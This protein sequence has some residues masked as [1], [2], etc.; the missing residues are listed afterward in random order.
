[1]LNE[2]YREVLVA[3]ATCAAGLTGLLFVAISVAPRESGR[4]TQ[5]TVIQQVRA[6]SALLAF[7]NA[8]AV[9][10]FSLVPGDTGGQAALAL[11]SIGIL[12]TAASVRS[13]VTSPH[14]SS[15]QAWGQAGLITIL[16]AAFGGEFGCG[17]GLITRRTE[18]F[19]PELLSNILIALLLIGIARSWELVG[20]RDTGLLSSLALLS[21][22]RHGPDE[23][24]DSGDSPGSGGSVS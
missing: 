14:V 9:S 1:M 17:I 20:K 11:A 6:A 19:G 5:P 18:V 21:G 12:F 3:V 13:I 4:S 2:S 7:T 16:L 23:P 10:L 8:M 22:I 15:Q 24:D